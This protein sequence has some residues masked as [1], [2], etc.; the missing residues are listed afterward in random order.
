LGENFEP[1]RSHHTQQIWLPPL[2][3]A[4]GHYLLT[5]LYCS[6]QPADNIPTRPKQLKIDQTII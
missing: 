5:A 1:E 4:C 2:R 3:S 6:V